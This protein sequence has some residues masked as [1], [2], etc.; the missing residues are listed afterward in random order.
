[1]TSRLTVTWH[2]VERFRERVSQQDGQA[3][4]VAHEVIRLI[5]DR[6]TP[7]WTI[8][9]DG[10]YPVTGRVIARVRAGKVVTVINK[11]LKRPR[12]VKVDRDKSNGVGADA[13]AEVGSSRMV[14][15]VLEVR[16]GDRVV[17]EYLVQGSDLDHLARMDMPEGWEAL[18]TPVDEA[19]WGDMLASATQ[20]AQQVKAHMDELAQAIA[21]SGGVMEGWGDMMALA[22]RAQKV[23]SSHSAAQR[24]QTVQFVQK[25]RPRPMKPRSASQRQKASNKRKAQKKGRRNNRKKRR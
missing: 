14:G 21:Q 20:K 13:L 4:W 10:D 24:G 12:G 18:V 6:V 23:A 3:P 9:G 2:A 19:T 17:G 1:M 22:Q 7:P 25:P 11:A 15:G 5:R 16:D 8:L